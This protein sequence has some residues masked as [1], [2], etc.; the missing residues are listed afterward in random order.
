MSKYTKLLIK[1]INTLM[2]TAGL[3]QSQLA[4]KL[5]IAPGNVN[6][7]LNGKNVPSVE[8]LASIADVFGVTVAELFKMDSPPEPRM[9]LPDTIRDAIHE[10][11]AKLLQ[12]INQKLGPVLTALG[13]DHGAE[14]I[15]FRN[16][17][18]EKLSEFI[19]HLLHDPGLTADFYRLLDEGADDET[20]R[21]EFLS[22]LIRGI[23]DTKGPLAIKVKKLM[24]E[25]AAEGKGKK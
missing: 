16:V 19:N 20:L 24:Q 25:L 23:L 17:P 21:L 15:V 13:R 14:E 4:V 10:G 2:K 12:Q 9:E 18:K 1:N 8:T 7:W 3:N 6:N 11:N 22:D 5:G